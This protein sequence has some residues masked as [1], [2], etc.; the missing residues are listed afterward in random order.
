MSFQGD[1]RGIGLAELLQGLARGRKEGLLTLSANNTPSSTLGIV[2]GALHLLP[3]PDEDPEIWRSRVRDAWA[4]E[5]AMRIDYLRMSEIARA[6][7]LEN[8]FQLLD[9]DGVHF[10]FDPG[11]LPASLKSGPAPN[12]TGEMAQKA[13]V[14]CDPIAVEFLLLEYARISDHIEGAGPGYAMSADVVPI[15]LDASRGKGSRI[16]EQINDNSTLREI[17]DRLGWPVRQCQVAVAEEIGRAGLRLATGSELLPL[18][19]KELGTKNFS[20]AGARLSAWCRMG[21]PGGLLQDEYEALS[22]EW[23]AGRLTATLK[24]M[25]AAAVRTMLRRMDH[26]AKNAATRSVYWQEASRAHPGDRLTRLHRLAAEFADRTAPSAPEVRELL[27]LARDFRDSSHAHRNRPVLVMAAHRQPENMS[28]QLEIGLGLVTAGLVQQGAPW[29]IN[30]ATELLDNNSADRAIPPLRA[31]LQADPRNRHVRQLLSRARRGSTQVKKLRKNLLVT[32][33]CVVVLACAAVVK[34]RVDGLRED[35][36]NSVRDLLSNPVAALARLESQF[37]GDQSVDVAKMRA[38][39]ES[40][41]QAEEVRKRLAWNDLFRAAQHECSI[42]DPVAGLRQTLDLPLPPELQLIREPWPLKSDLYNSL[43][44]ALAAS[45]QDLGLAAEDE[46]EQLTGEGHFEDRSAV[47]REMLEEESMNLDIAQ[48]LEALDSLDTLLVKR[49]ELRTVIREE[50]LERENLENQDDLLAQ[51]RG[52]ALKGDYP[53]A[54]R[55]YNELLA[56]DAEGRVAEV[57]RDEIADV[58]VKQETVEEARALA[59]QGWHAEARALL[60]EKLPDPESFLLPWRVDTFPSGA[61]VQLST[62]PPRPTPFLIETTIGEHVSL[63]IELEGFETLE[64]NVTSPDDLFLNLSR[65]TERTWRGDGRVDAP[66]VGIAGDHLMVDRMGKIARVAEGG[67]IVWE[68]QVQT[69]SGIASAPVSL[70]RRPGFFLLVTED[71]QAWIAAAEDGSLEGPLDL[72]A[73]LVAGPYPSQNDVC[74]RLSDGRLAR[75]QNRLKPTFVSASLS[76]S[77]RAVEE[78]YRFGSSAGLHLLRRRDSLEKELPCSWND[79][80][81]VVENDTYHVFHQDEPAGGY[82]V[83]RTGDWEYLG[84]E[85]PNGMIPQ[86]RLWISDSSGVRS[87]VPW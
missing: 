51:A 66:P 58:E 10:R 22:Q 54:L 59:E 12:L 53:R 36:L 57:L 25:S 34:L 68:K 16:Y 48:F 55:L 61:T 76:Q 81:I 69:L 20:R 27:D 67:R 83:Q 79:W 14:T 42:G 70:P 3:D 37:P 23:L 85:A 71:G 4:D 13:E 52:H 77:A 62:G 28:Q 11:A 26:T 6:Q 35:R 18:A 82:R 56:T 24:V 64:L 86:G 15:V 40:A 32:L 63:T 46:P 87:F 30:A 80:R 29:I 49:R 7:R 65:S 72:G 8:L 5:E 50:R 9:G 41:Q 21:R 84:W 31:L 44:E 47:L 17:A 45:L 74:A 33:S 38:D 75:W 2:Q 1:V 39:I 19:I 73:T 78:S 60:E 43:A